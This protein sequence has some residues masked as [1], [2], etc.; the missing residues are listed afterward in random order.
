M[1]YRVGDAVASVHNHNGHRFL[2]F[3]KL[4]LYWIVRRQLLHYCLKLSI[5]CKCLSL[6]PVS[7]TVHIKYLVMI[8]LRRRKIYTIFFRIGVV[9]VLLLLLFIDKTTGNSVQCTFFA[10]FSIEFWWNGN[11]LWK[12]KIINLR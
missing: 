6:A 7:C 9:F 8:I 1:A 3:G 12:N 10:G 11:I 5:N 4:R 2:L